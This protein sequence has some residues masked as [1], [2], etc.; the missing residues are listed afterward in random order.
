[1]V[2]KIAFQVPQSDFRV[3][4]SL[5]ILNSTHFVPCEHSRPC[6]SSNIRKSNRTKPPN[7]VPKHGTPANGT[8]PQQRGM[9]GRHS[10]TIAPKKLVP[11]TQQRPTRPYCR[12]PWIGKHSTGIIS[13]ASPIAQRTR[14]SFTWSFAVGGWCIP[15]IITKINIGVHKTASSRFA[16]T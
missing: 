6:I 14:P 9:S 2:P 5:K 4:L 10:Q 11:S 16:T 3:Q 1:V 8:K 12:N 13:E 7:F 15:I